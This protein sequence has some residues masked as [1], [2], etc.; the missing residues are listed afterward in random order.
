MQT[1]GFT[2]RIH[3]ISVGGAVRTALGLAVYLTNSSLWVY[4]PSNE[5]ALGDIRYI[6]T[7]FNLPPPPQLSSVSVSQ[8]YTADSVGCAVN[9]QTSEGISVNRDRISDPASHLKL[10]HPNHFQSFPSSSQQPVFPA[11]RGISVSL[12]ESARLRCSGSLIYFVI[13]R[14]VDLHV[15]LIYRCCKNTIAEPLSLS[16]ASYI[17]A[18]SLNCE[19]FHTGQDNSVRTA[20]QDLHSFEKAR[21]S[22]WGREGHGDKG[23]DSHHEVNSSSRPLRRTTLQHIGEPSIQGSSFGQFHTQPLEEREKEVFGAQGSL[24]T[25]SMCPSQPMLVGYLYS[26]ILGHD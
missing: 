26:A 21:L 16:S 23:G 25:A 6:A 17:T 22:G 5:N 24:G 11:V 13:K 1:D 3:Y 14:S 7:A 20:F 12:I 8:V 4:W 15:T 9:P 2:V 19:R 18:T 10:V